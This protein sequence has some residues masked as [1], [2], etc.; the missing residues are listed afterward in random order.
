MI[1]DSR[2]RWRL[3]L[4]IWLARRRRHAYD[5]RRSNPESHWCKC[6]SPADRD[7]KWTCVATDIDITLSAVFTDRERRA[8]RVADG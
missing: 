3:N 1:R 2:N 8:M 7:W 5:R 6:G 4:R